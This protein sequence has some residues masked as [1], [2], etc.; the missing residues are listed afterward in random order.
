[1]RIR[2]YM[3]IF[4]FLWLAL[5][6]V[7]PFLV[8]A[9]VPP[10]QED[11]NSKKQKL[12][13]LFK[14]SGLEGLKNNITFRIRDTVLRHTLISY[15]Q[16]KNKDLEKYAAF[17]DSPAGKW[18]IQAQLRGFKKEIKNT[19]YKASLI[20]IEWL[21]E[22]N[23][24]G[25]YSPL[26]K[27]RIPTGQRLLLVGGRDPF[28]P[29]VNEQGFVSSPGTVPRKSLVRLYGGEFRDITPLALPIFEKIKNKYPNLYKELT[30]FQRLFNDRKALEEMEDE[31]YTAAIKNYRIILKRS[32]HIK[33]KI[34]PLQIKYDGLQMTGIILKKKE[35]LALFEVNN[36]GYAVKRGDWIGPSF[37]TVKEVKDGQVIVVEKF[38]DYLG[39]ILK[40]QKVI[41]FR[42]TSLKKVKKY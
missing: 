33:M 15:R 35:G 39:N 26:L 6:G 3:K 17:L 18:F 7:K 12:N 30:G 5:S 27:N 10:T 28:R 24:D 42:K 16:K 19:A 11:Q 4:F 1:M 34:S 29:L 21:N 31:E 8:S 40:N 32:A 38:R 22:V 23:S 37:G 9:V 14:L 25:P 41:R 36:T 20:K 2:S 13:T